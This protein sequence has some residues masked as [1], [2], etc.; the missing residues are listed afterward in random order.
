MFVDLIIFLIIIFDFFKD[1]ELTIMDDLFEVKLFQ[2]YCVRKKKQKS[3]LNFLRIL[4]LF[5]FS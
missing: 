4:L 1:F 5:F 3:L 2:N